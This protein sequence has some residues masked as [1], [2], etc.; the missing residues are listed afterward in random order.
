MHSRVIGGL[1]FLMGVYTKQGVATVIEVA[2]KVGRKNDDPWCVH[3]GVSQWQK[4]DPAI[5]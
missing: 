4:L 5:N 1:T 3:G 2:M